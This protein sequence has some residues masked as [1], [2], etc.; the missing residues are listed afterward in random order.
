MER[1]EFDFS[2]Y[3]TTLENLKFGE[4]TYKTI[5][6]MKAKKSSE[7]GKGY[8]IVEH[9]INYFIVYKIDKS[10]EF[11]IFFN[12]PKT[13]NYTNLNE[14]QNLIFSTLQ[15]DE[16]IIKNSIQELELGQDMGEYQGVY[17]SKFKTGLGNI[18]KDVFNF[19]AIIPFNDNYVSNYK[20][21]LNDKFSPLDLSK[22][23][24]DYF[25]YNNPDDKEEFVYYE[26]PERANLLATLD[27]FYFSNCNYFKF[28]GPISGGKSTTL[29]KF[30]NQYVGIL[31]FNL[32]TIKKFYLNGN[33]KY[34]SIMLY[35]MRSIM[36]NKEKQKDQEEELNK[37]IQNNEILEIIFSELIEFLEKLKIRNI[38]VIDQFRNSDFDSST[39]DKIQ[40]KI[41]NSLIGLIL[42]SSIDEKEIKNELI[43]TLSK[44]YKM[45]KVY[46]PKNQNYYFYIPNL[47][48]NKII[49]ENYISQNKFS[50]DFIDLFEQFSF[51]TQ[52][53]SLL[54]K[55]EGIDENFKIIH[56]QITQKM[57]NQNIFPTSVSLEF[58]LLL[59]NEYIDKTL[60]YKEE[61]FNLLRKIPLKFIDVHFDDNYFS[62]HYG[63]PYIKTLVED[64]KK[65]LDIKNY[66]EKNMFT[67]KF[68]TQFKGP[69]FEKAVINSIIDRKLYLNKDDQNNE[70]IY[71]IIVNN[72]LD[73]KET[74]K[75]NNAKTIINRINNKVKKK[76]YEEKEYNTY[77][78][79]RI[80]N[81]EELLNE[82]NKINFNNFLEQALKEE[83]EIL[84]K[85]LEKIKNKKKSENKY[86]K[87]IISLYDEKFTN[88][89]ILIEQIQPTG[90]AVDAAFLFGNK[91][92][93][94][95]ILLQMKFY[96]K[97][98]GV[99]TEEKQKLDKLYIQNTCKKVL[100]NIYLNLGIKIETWHYIL[101]LYFNS[102]DETYN[103]SLVRI[104]NN[105]DL[106]YI[107]FDPLENKFYNKEK[108]QIKVLDLNFLTNLNDIEF[109]SNPIKC[110]QETEIIKSYITKRNR[111]LTKKISY[112]EKTK[113]FIQ[114]FENK[115]KVSFE[116]FFKKIKNN[117]KNI[118]N[119]KVISFL[120]ME[121]N[122]YFPILK[123]GYG[124]IFLNNNQNG[125]IFMGKLKNNENYIILDNNNKNEIK[126]L[127]LNS[128]I[129]IEEEFIYFVVKLT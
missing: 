78:D 46:S 118:K 74:D 2:Q 15:I 57:Q 105:N 98:S 85:E 66:F 1:N 45:P 73:M 36:L 50:N 3:I 108:K 7:L 35:E 88:G 59:I 19:K 43:L 56:N 126:F 29:L 107:F 20:L 79:D 120:N 115:Y 22:F 53:I 82:K 23:F 24:Y 114:D 61:N 30:K 94:T 100:S 72:I 12:G 37:I 60:E 125:L 47:L 67:E 41:N 77:I 16:F 13:V 34:K 122:K 124:Y 18:K 93:K 129:N 5:Y 111:D 106:E 8:R 90:K 10:N 86:D 104:C 76:P 38:L 89:N 112:K 119:I 83:L 9:S 71:K 62:L 51:K 49:K 42:S 26:T 69:Y 127:K 39:F 117:F 95:L 58:I 128:F 11:G 87:Q 92:E 6:E 21:L 70:K 116:N 96:E 44:F 63:F 40:K 27:N 75:E 64:S 25:E 68:Y 110:F 65:K 113:K 103:T 33:P 102:K 91:N 97:T 81:I 52:Y 80:K 121:L 17:Y 99:S 4:L 54:K 123:D 31:Y 109:E 101:I 14:S 28:C 48:G 84:K 32:K 55:K